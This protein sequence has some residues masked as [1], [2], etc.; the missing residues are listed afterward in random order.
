[1]D[2]IFLSSPHMGGYEL[3]YVH[4]AFETNW[5][6]PL[7]ENV[8]MFE[9]ELAEYV[10]IGSAAALSS[11]T[12]AIHLALKAAGVERGDA[13]FCSFLQIDHSSSPVS[14]GIECKF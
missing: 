5:I 11:G 2:R 13:V 14:F 1:M 12:A 3:D 7:G 8:N 4:Q 6:A 10:G 9:K